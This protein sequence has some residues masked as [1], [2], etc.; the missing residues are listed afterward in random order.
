MRKDYVVGLLFNDT[1]TMVTL[2]EKKKFPPGFDWAANPLNGVGGKL[3]PGEHWHAA[4]V[5]EFEE[6]TGVK[7]QQTDWNFFLELAAEDNSWMVAF[8]RCFSSEFMSKTKTM[9]EEKIVEV[10]TKPLLRV[11]PNLH[12][13]IPMALRKEVWFGA[14]KEKM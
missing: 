14:V 6:E 13:I 10:A 5:R 12:W 4:V 8:Y 2:V 9:E 1:G 11:V 3:E 7:T